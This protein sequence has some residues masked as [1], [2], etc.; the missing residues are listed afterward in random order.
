[1]SSLGLRPR[2]DIQLPSGTNPIHLET[3]GTNITCRTP[4]CT[5]HTTCTP[6]PCKVHNEGIPL[7][8]MYI[9]VADICAAYSLFCNNYYIV[10]HRMSQTIYAG[11]LT[12]IDKN[13]SNITDSTPVTKPLSKVTILYF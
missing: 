9:L 6:S 4:L 5:G 7:Y 11:L 1:M 8:T 2:E 12:L 10:I 13:V 3:H